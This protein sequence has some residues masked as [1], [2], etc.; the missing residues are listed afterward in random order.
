MQQMAKALRVVSVE[1]GH[2]PRGL[3]LVPFGGAGGLHQAALAAEL[4]F[5]RVL[6][7]PSRGPVGAGPAGR[8]DHGDRARTVLVGLDDADLASLTAVLD[9]LTDRGQQRTRQQ[10]VDAAALHRRRRPALPRPGVR[11]GGPGHGPPRPALADGSTRAPGTLRL[12]PARLAGRGGD[13]A[14]PGRGSGPGRPAPPLDRWRA[15]D[16][17]VTAVRDDGGR[18]RPRARVRPQPA[19]RGDAGPGSGRRRR[20]GR[21][22]V[23]APWQSG[24]VDDLGALHL[25]EAGT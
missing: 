5:A 3:T 16:G 18:R 22:R 11:T 25:Q 10:G 9:E 15:A 24:E 7:P 14:G 23:V 4:G 21:H 19:G 8:T 17:A 2:D 1:Q 20:A 12:R 13:T 6:V